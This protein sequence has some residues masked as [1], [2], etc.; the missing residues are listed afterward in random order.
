[1][2]KEISEKDRAYFA[3]LLDGEGCILINKS[4]SK[5]YIGYGFYVAFDIT[6]KK[7]LLEMQGLF[8][9]NIYEKDM[10][11]VMSCDSSRKRLESGCYL[12]NKQK[13]S[14][15][16]KL[17]GRD[18]LYF[19]KVV[20]PFCREKKEQALLGIKYEQGR[21]TNAGRYGRSDSETERCEFFYREL[22]RLKHEQPDETDAEIDF[23]D[24]QQKLFSFEVES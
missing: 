13:Q 24:D 14:Y 15:M 7:V 23:I 20:E 17:S 5:N 12:S 9:G 19:L 11:K 21:R 8:S 4:V 16:Y 18:A 10:E 2:I 1:M 6:Y 3:G 22:Q